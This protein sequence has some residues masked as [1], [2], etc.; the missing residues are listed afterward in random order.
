MPE[1]SL[2][3]EIEQ[4]L[5]L[6][7]DRVP[8]GQVHAHFQV[9]RP[10]RQWMSDGSWIFWVPLASLRLLGFKSRVSSDDPGGGLASGL[11][12][13]AQFGTPIVITDPYIQRRN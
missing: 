7:R 3:Q 11:N 4:M 5:Q 2:E 10:Y 8:R 13:A 6:V 1:L 12:M 9:D